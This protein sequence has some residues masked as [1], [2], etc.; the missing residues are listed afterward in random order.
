MLLLHVANRKRRGQSSA[1]VEKQTTVQTANL[2]ITTAQRF[3][4][5]RHFREKADKE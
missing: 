2:S 1:H 5:T 4:S 3:S